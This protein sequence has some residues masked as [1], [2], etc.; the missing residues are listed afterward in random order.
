MIK[1]HDKNNCFAAHCPL[2]GRNKL[3]NPMAYVSHTASHTAGMFSDT[4]V[5]SIRISVEMIFLDRTVTS[6]IKCELHQAKQM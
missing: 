2:V 4:L 5:P 1:L 3:N 6:K